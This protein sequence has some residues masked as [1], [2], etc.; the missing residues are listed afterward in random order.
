MGIA[1][2]EADVLADVAEWFAGQPREPKKQWKNTKLRFLP[3]AIMDKT[4]K[5]TYFG[6]S[7]ID[8]TWYVVAIDTVF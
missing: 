5:T 1:H 3:K 8:A 4:H 6:D 7:A 2:L